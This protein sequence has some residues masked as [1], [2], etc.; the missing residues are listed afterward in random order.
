[1]SMSKKAETILATAEQLFTVHGFHAT[2]VDRIAEES[3]VTKRTLYKHFG[4][5]EGLIQA[6]LERHHGEIMQDVRQKVQKASDARAKILTCFSIWRAWFAKP[7]FAGCIFIKTLNEYA[8]CSTEI[9]RVAQKAK[10]EMRSFLQE[11]AEEAGATDPAL[12]AEQ[13]QILLEGA[14]VLAQSGR[15]AATMDSADLIVRDLLD[16]A[17]P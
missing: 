13:L 14:T 3:G 17:I 11:L 5:K 8:G 1:M 16:R 9:G 10:D 6:V 4:S 7:E 12:L 15:G 2:G